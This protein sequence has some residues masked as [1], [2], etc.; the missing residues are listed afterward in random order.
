MTESVQSKEIIIAPKG[1]YQE[2]F[3]CL[4]DCLEHTSIVLFDGQLGA[5]KTT[6]IKELC[7]HF[8]LITDMSSPS[9]S[10]INLHPV[11]QGSRFSSIAHMD[12][13]RL[14]STEEFIEIGGEDYLFDE[15][16]LCLIEWPEL[17]LPLIDSFV[18]VQLEILPSGGRKLILSLVD[19][20]SRV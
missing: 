6:M 17:A 4:N 19:I 18:G 12:L 11:S 7:Q 20:N 5:G 15:K 10:L 2:A 1:S 3:A 13:Y 16:T 8:W 14:K 9:Y